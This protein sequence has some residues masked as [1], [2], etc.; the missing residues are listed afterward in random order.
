MIYLLRKNIKTKMLSNKLDHIKL[1]L[2]R[3]KK[4]LKLVTFKLI[5]S[6]EIKIHPVFHKSLLKPGAVRCVKTKTG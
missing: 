1:R 2:F 3:I 5:L 6:K 4:K